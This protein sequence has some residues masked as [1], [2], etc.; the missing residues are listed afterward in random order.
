[1]RKRGEVSGKPRE[2]QDPKQEEDGQKA[3]MATANDA[4]LA[5]VSASS[6]GYY[7]DPFLRHLVKDATGHSLADSTPSSFSEAGRRHEQ[8]LQRHHL[9]RQQQQPRHHPF[10]HHHNQQQQQQQPIIRRGTHARVCVMDRAIASFM[11]LISQQSS[12][13]NHSGEKVEAQIVLLGS[14]RDTTY[15]RAQSNLLL[16]PP[17]TTTSSRFS[18]TS[19]DR[20]RPRVAWYEV[21]HPSMIQTKSHLLS[22]CPLLD[23]AVTKRCNRTVN[24]MEGLHGN[25]HEEDDFSFFILP[26]SVAT[27]DSTTRMGNQPSPNEKQNKHME[28]YYLIGHDLRGHHQQLMDLLCRKFSFRP[29]LPTLFL[30]ECVQMYLPGKIIIIHCSVYLLSSFCK[31]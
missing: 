8:N 7:K 31:N 19:C 21:D 18:E 13:S 30:L 12:P 5:K 6:K 24:E 9:R 16:N 17:A 25:V 15:L 11:T 28:P 3:I 10:H 29:D 4:I 2:G 1:M 26:N 23:I 20:T 22:I 27:I 14:G